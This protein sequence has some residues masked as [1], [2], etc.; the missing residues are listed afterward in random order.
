MQQES[1][2]DVVNMRITQRILGR[3]LWYELD[4]ERLIQSE[5]ADRTEQF[6]KRIWTHNNLFD[7]EGDSHYEYSE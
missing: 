2:E 5:V 4:K 3:L 6:W 7:D 1:K